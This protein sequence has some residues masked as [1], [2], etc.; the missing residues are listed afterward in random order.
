MSHKMSATRLLLVLA[1]LLALACQIALPG[2]PSPLPWATPTSPASPSP[3]TSPTATLSPTATPTPTPRPADLLEL[4]E[5]GLFIGDLEGASLAFQAAFDGA[6]D[7]ETAAQALLGL[8]R[9]HLQDQAFEE[10]IEALKLLIDRYPDSPLL[11]KARFLLAE[12]LTGAGRP[13]EAA[14]Q[15]LAYPEE[16]D[17]SITPYLYEWIGDALRAAG[18]EEGAA[19]AYLAALEEP[20]SLSAEVGLR[21]KLALTYTALGAYEEALAQYEA[22][23]TRAQITEYRARIAYQ[24]AETLLLAGRIEEAY[25]RYHEVVVSY[26]SSPWAYQSLLALVDAGE[27]VDDLTRGIVDYYAGAYGPAVA[28][29]YRYIEA[30]ADHE[31]SAHY[32]AGLAHLSAGS[33]ALA[34]AQ[35]Q[36]LVQTHPESDRWGDGWMGWAEALAAQGDLEGAVKTYRTFAQVAPD[37]PRAPEA[38]WTAAQRLERAGQLEE[39]A[40]AYEDCAG[41]YPASEYAAPALL[42]AGLQHYRLG[43]LEQA[44]AD[45]ET[46]AETYPGSEYRAAGL[47]WLGKGYLATGQPLS[48]TAALSQAVEI[49]PTGY[50]GLRAADLLADPLAPPF[51][52][53]DY[54]PPSDPD[55]GR[56]QAEAWLADWVGLPPEEELD[57]VEADLSA[58]PRLRRGVELWELGRREEA[59]AELEALR[60]ATAD[61]PVIQYR[62]AL[63]FRDLGL[64]RSS[65]LAAVRVIHLSPA[66]TP[67]DVPP[68]L[69]RLAYPVYYEDLILSSALAKDLPPLLMFSLVRQESLFEGFA[70]SFAYAHGLMQVIPSTG[71][72]IAEELAWPPGYDTAD[73]YRPLVSVRFGTWYLARQRDRFGG[74]LDVALAAYNGGPAN[75]AHWLEAA[76]NDPDVFFELITLGETRLYL[77]RIREHYAVYAQLYGR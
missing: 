32:F 21:E 16:G 69:A 19:A 5:E 76:G 41:Q 26:P 14:E 71:A 6:P 35:F 37:H 48:A 11:P 74:R 40:R 4:G 1:G 28:A 52:P 7:A 56:A 25:S 44:I 12:A 15:Y 51:P 54:R 55:E 22:I 57:N 36:T 70:T 47:L 13:A 17:T 39:A 62:L 8:G 38:L 43:K 30:N 23:L 67:L 29:L 75:A 31:G 24:A 3:T 66:R 20:P 46:L 49:D 27:P 18:D 63:L 10:A 33:P 34:A 64:Y 65:V 45:W 58:D 50:Y 9:T 2:L 68:F 60:Q 61:D 59:K 72:A 77:Q 42:R 53:T 73:L